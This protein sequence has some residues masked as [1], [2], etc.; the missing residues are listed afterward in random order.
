[1]LKVINPVGREVDYPYWESETGYRHHF[2]G[3]AWREA[4]VF[5]AARAQDLGALYQMTGQ[6]EYARRA[7]LI[8]DAFARYYPGFLVSLDRASEQKGF[9]LEPP[10]PNNGGKWG[11][12][13]HDEMPIGPVFAYDSI[14]GSGEIERLAEEVGVDVRQRIEQ[15][16]F[17]GAIRQDG[18]HGPMYTNAS[19]RIYQGHAMIG[20]VLGDPT[21]V[22]EA[23]C[24]SVGLFERRVFAEGLWCEGSPGYHRMTL[25]GMQGVFDALRGYSDP[26]GYEDPEDGKRFED[27]DVERDIPIIDRARKILDTCR[28]PDGRLFVLHDN[29]ARFDDLKVPDRS[30]STL[31]PGAGHAWL[32]MGEGEEQVQAHLHFSG[33]YGHEHA[34]NLNLILFAKGHELL[35]DVGYT[36]TRYRTWSTS[37]VCHNT[38]A[39]DGHRQYT[40]GARGPSDGRLEAFETA[41]EKVQWVEVRAEAAYPGLAQTYRRLLMLVDAGGGAYYVVDVFRVTG[42]SKHD[43]LLH[44]SADA[45][46]DA[47]VSVP[48]SDNVEHM[49]SDVSVRFPQHERDPGEA[50]G[51]NVNYAFVQNVAQGQVEDSL[52][53]LFRLKDGS[54]GVRSHLA[55]VSGA[56]V[57][58]GDSPSLRRSEENETLLDKYRMPVVVVRREGEPPLESRFT[59]VHEPF[60]DTRF[61]EAVSVVPVPG[62]EGAV[63]ISVRHH[64]VTDHI[65]HRVGP[66]SGAV[67]VGD[68]QL[69]GEVGFVR[70]RD[71]A[72]EQMGLG[73]GAELRWKGRTL[74]AGGVYEFDVKAV[75]READG[76]A[77]NALV[78]RGYVPEGEALKGGT[79]RVTFGNGS[80]RGYGIR[81]VQQVDGSVHVLLVEDPGFVVDGQG[82]RHLFFPGD[83]ISG[84][85]RCRV[86]ASAFVDLSSGSRS[87]VGLAVFPEE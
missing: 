22:H 23:V 75:L 13:R 70:E 44:G 81:S 42:G 45:D 2:S 34:D 15:D 77:Y 57:F 78:G 43:W 12:W 76:A 83:E 7:A 61:I 41:H 9:V 4:R 46:M 51:R 16:F 18:F 48:L 53:V 59:A 66:V 72:V 56:Q 55:D 37:T 6:Q 33:G 26:P 52:T 85:V 80:V 63:S 82:M 38:V 62:E 29:W 11:R 74:A 8:L 32:G 87:S 73:G 79:A 17:M 84:P 49:I 50:E 3:K 27:L 69:Q 60:G 47:E 54:A 31:L 14:S 40:K 25:R 1:L 86:L 10:Y 67:V 58:L 65:L 36:H 30:V 21:L 24:R 19:P 64:G 71:G 39:I 35:P 68:M 20:R 28:Y 5:F